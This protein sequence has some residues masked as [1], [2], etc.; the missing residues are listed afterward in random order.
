MIQYGYG[1]RGRFPG[2]LILTLSRHLPYLTQ[3]NINPNPNTKPNPNR[4]LSPT[5]TLTPTNVSPTPTVILPKTNF[6]PDRRRSCNYNPKP[7]PYP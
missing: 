1:P 4:T 2:H 5:A 6:N 7:N 3:P